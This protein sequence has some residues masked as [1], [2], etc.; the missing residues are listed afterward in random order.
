M[1]DNIP[2]QQFGL[3][4]INFDSS[5]V[6]SGVGSSNVNIL[7]QQVLRKAKPYYLGRIQDEVLEFPLSFASEN[8]IDGRDRNIISKWLFGRSEYKPLTIIQDDLNGAWFNCFLTD[9]EP[10]YIGN[11]TYGF[12]CKVVCDSPFAYSPLKTITRTFYRG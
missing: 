1:F 5:G 7:T 12:K 11:V 6:E 3:K 8:P 2:S 4:I 9:P 10:V